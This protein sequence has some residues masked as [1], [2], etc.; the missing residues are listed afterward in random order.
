MKK[1]LKV[2]N[3]SHRPYMSELRSVVIEFDITSLTYKKL[4]A[5]DFALHPDKIYWVHCTL[6][7]EQLLDALAKKLHLSDSLLKLCKDEN[8][9]QRVIDTADDL[10][11][12]IPCASRNNLVEN[13]NENLIIYLKEN[14]C[15]TA[16]Y[17]EHPILLDILENFHKNLRYALTPGFV[18][19]L[20]LDSVIN[21]YSSIL[22]EYEEV[23][24]NIDIQT[25]EMHEGAYSQV[26][27]IKKQVT[28]IK[29]YVSSLR[30]VLMRISGRKIP[31][32]SEACRLSLGNLFSH[33]QTIVNETDAIRDILNSTLDLLDNSLMQKMNGT[34]KIL[35]GFSAIFLPLTVI[36]GIYGMN[37]HWIPELDWKYGYFYALF[38]MLLCAAS[39]M[40]LFKKKKW[41]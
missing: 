33:C 16:S 31:V 34:M 12:Q 22:Q 17:S 2:L 19:F 10:C 14:Y 20:L 26:M 7:D 25:R 41:F 38:L 28:K 37:F 9:S 27:A 15:F 30:D 29:R 11:L 36:T 3:K 21:D 18:L 8:T 40:F 24:D 32:I 39:L 6:S 1:D 35:T 4:S 5:R 23:A 13:V